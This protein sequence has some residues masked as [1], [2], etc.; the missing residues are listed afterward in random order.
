[1][2]L[3]PDTRAAC[4]ER[5]VRAEDLAIDRLDWVAADAD[6]FLDR[7]SAAALGRIVEAPPECKA[8]D[9]D[10]LESAAVGDVIGREKAAQKALMDPRPRARA[11]SPSSSASRP[12]CAR[13]DVAGE[14]RGAARARRR[15]RASA[16][17]ERRLG[18]GQVGP[19]PA[20]GQEGDGRGVDLQERHG[21]TRARRCA[22]GGARLELGPRPRRRRARRA[23]G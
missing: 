23:A 14:T 5:F 8:T 20:A 3:R 9:K 21:D 2:K 22:R 19:Q 17:A 13:G 4:E 11:S 16:A 6:P 10:A 7:I 15:A 12:S 18:P 1:V